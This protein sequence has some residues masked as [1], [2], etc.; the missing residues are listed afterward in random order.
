MN[1]VFLMVKF[2]K[3]SITNP[4]KVGEEAEV[5]IFLFFFTNILSFEQSNNFT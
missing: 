2:N 3:E 4:I 1:F 5:A